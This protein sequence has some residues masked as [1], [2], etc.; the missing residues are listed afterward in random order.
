[1]GEVEWSKEH[2]D[3]DAR[4]N[5]PY[6][7][8]REEHAN[9]CVRCGALERVGGC[10]NCGS[11][12]YVAGYDTRGVAGLFCKK[13]NKGYTNYTCKSCGT[14]NAVANTFGTLSSKGMCFIATAAFESIE[15]PEV[16]FL[17]EFRDKVLLNQ[18]TG[19]IFVRTY[20]K[21]SPPV[22]EVVSHSQMLRRSSRMVLRRLVR[23]LK[24]YK[25]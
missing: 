24:R 16:V 5:T 22:A 20:Y 19:R 8:D 18:A 14:E 3:I 25:E 15:A 10:P 6:H 11:T 17:R 2:L 9:K 7:V 12:W 4:D 13:C 23:Y 1:M 21:L